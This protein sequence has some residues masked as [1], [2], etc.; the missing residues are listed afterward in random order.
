MKVFGKAVLAALLVLVVG[1]EAVA[2]QRGEQPPQ[3]QRKEPAPTDLVG[4][5]EY[6]TSEVDGEKRPYVICAT[7][8]SD[9]PKPA[10]LVVSPGGT[11]LQGAQYLTG[12]F[13]TTIRDAGKSAVILRPTGRG[14]GSLYMNYGEVDLFE[15]VRDA[16]TK[17]AIDPDRISVMGHSMGGAATWYLTSHYPDFFSA[18][19][20]SSGY[21]DYRLWEKPGGYTF[22][23]QEWE[24]P[25]WIARSAVFVPENFMHTPMWVIHGE[26]DRS[27]GGG[28]PVEHSRR[29]TSLL[30]DHGSPYKYTEVEGMGHHFLDK[31]PEITKN[32]LLWLIDQKKERSPEHVKVAAYTLRHNKSYWVAIEQL[33]YYGKRGMVDAEFLSPERLVVRVQ[34]VRTFSLGPVAGRSAVRLNLEGQELGE[35]DLS[36]K[37]M[38]RRS[39]EGKWEAGDFDLSKEKRHSSSG[40][41][42]DLFFDNT[43]LVVGTAGSQSAAQYSGSV[44]GH[45]ATRYYTR[46]GGVHRGGIMGDN[47]V[48]LLVVKDSELTEEERKNS[49]L[50]LYG[51]FESNSVMKM[52]EGKLPIEFDGKVIRVG[53]RTYAGDDTTV[54]TVLPHPEN[55]DRCVA[56]HGGVTDDAITYGSHIDLGLLPDYMVYSKGQLLDWGFWG[57]DWKAQQ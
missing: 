1:F 57:N 12:Q 28:V 34:N 14:G 10:V 17:Y 19:N 42:A 18:G 27:I 23:M 48:K 41:I 25:S 13:A 56:V 53:G 24:E 3:R 22:H 30:A 9:Q 33:D 46:N 4:K 6:Y 35:V 44:A 47:I 50:I 5:I 36:A 21:C 52:F 11:G 49:N 20:P 38:F 26:L 32:S 51:T 45:Q 55:P 40:P 54:F 43:I 39:E 37:T 8:E 2:Q 16:M 31:G 29:M 15:A 7:N